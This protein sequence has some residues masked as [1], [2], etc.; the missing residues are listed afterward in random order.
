MIMHKNHHRTIENHHRTL[1]WHYDV[2][3]EPMM[4]SE[5]II[6]SHKWHSILVQFSVFLHF[7]F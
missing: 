5:V 4:M 3:M 1:E 7:D 2:S 6:T